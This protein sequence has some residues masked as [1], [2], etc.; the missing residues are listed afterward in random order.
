MISFRSKVAVAI[1]DYFF[2]NPEARHYINEL[3][4]KLDLDPKNVYRKLIEFEKEGLLNS[5]IQ[6]KEKFFFLND[7]FPL[8]EQYRQIFLKTA[9]LEDILKKLLE[10]MTGIS[11]AYIFGS[12]AKNRMDSS[13]DIDV[14]VIG[15]HSVIELQKKIIKIQKET[16][17]EFNLINIGSDEFKKKRAKHDPLLKNIFAGKVIKLI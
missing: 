6:G 9:G 4:K 5:F 11:E 1:L 8:L 2:L 10:G 15:G 14:L 12:Y 7:K 17:R 3:A 13:S 16:G